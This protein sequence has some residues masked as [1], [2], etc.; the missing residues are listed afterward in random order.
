MRRN[1]R[2][3]IVVAMTAA[4]ILPISTVAAATT[5]VTYKLAGIASAAIFPQVSFTGAALAES[6]RELGV[7]NAV[8]SQDLGVILDGTFTF[9][10]RVH[11]LEDTIAGG[12]F[13]TGTFGQPAGNCAKTTI[14]VHGVLSGGGSFDVTLTRYGSLRSG[15]CVVYLSTVRGTATLVFP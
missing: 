15:S 2:L 10:S 9:K 6:R 8:F 4:L 5:T 12:T 11:A 7:W 14:P 1:S 3:L 13:G